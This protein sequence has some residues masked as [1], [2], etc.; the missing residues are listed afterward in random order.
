MQVCI[1]QRQALLT[2]NS[3]GRIGFVFLVTYIFVKEYY[4]FHY[5]RDQT[6]DEEARPIMIATATSGPLLTGSRYG[7][8]QRVEPG[9]KR[10]FAIP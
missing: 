2:L 9:R 4:S 7:G 1:P 5:H 10:E 6:H 8:S 3:R